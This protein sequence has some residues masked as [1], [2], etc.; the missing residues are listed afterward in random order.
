MRFR[1]SRDVWEPRSATCFPAN[2]FADADGHTLTYRATKTTLPPCRRGWL[3]TRP[4]APSQAHLE[5]ADVGTLTVRVTASDGN[6]GSVRDTFDITIRSSQVFDEDEDFHTQIVYGSSR[7]INLDDYLI[8][9]VSNVTYEVTSCDA[10]RADYFTTPEI[11]TDP[12]DEDSTALTYLSLTTNRLGH[13]HNSNADKTSS[14]YATT[15]T[16]TGTTSAGSASH[17]FSFSITAPRMRR[18][19]ASLTA[20]GTPA[21]AFR[22]VDTASGSYY[23]F[24]GIRPTGTE[25]F[26]NYIAKGVTKTT[27]LVVPGLSAGTYD[28]AVR[29]M[30]FAGYEL[31]AL[32]DTTHD[33]G[34]LTREGTYDS[35]WRVHLPIG[36]LS[37]SSKRLRGVQV[38][39]TKTLSIADAEGAGRRCDDVHR[40]AQRSA[41]NRRDRNGESPIAASIARECERE[42]RFHERRLPLPFQRVRHPRPSTS[43]PERTRPLSPT[44]PSLQY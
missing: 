33:D 29:L 9:G 19:L 35:K 8:D 11:V 44:R 30:S 17:E 3:L 15:C 40:H 6:G 39:A 2:T 26:T 37:E 20:V 41:R 5:P 7:S 22:A 43:P 24:F 4:R 13:V 38:G 31:R 21:T 14:A 23:I 34:V 36:G 42:Y 28:V 10:D 27:D 18:I 25:A 1:I 16:I 12:D 32:G